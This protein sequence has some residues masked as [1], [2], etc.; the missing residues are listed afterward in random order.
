MGNQAVIVKGTS[1]TISTSASTLVAAAMD[2]ETKTPLTQ[3]YPLAD[4]MLSTA[5]A[6]APTAMGRIDVYRHDLN[7]DGINDTPTPIATYTEV[8]IGSFIV[9]ATTSTQYP[10]LRGVPVSA[11]CTFYLKNS[12]D[13]TMSI[14]WVLKAMPWTYGLAA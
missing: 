12:T 5:F 7:I 11:D 8:F 2:S 3:T 1:V 14:G 13:Q 10:I 6:S 4:L 9:S